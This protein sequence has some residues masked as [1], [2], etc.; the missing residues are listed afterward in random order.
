MNRTSFLSAY[1]WPARTM[2][3]ALIVSLALIAVTA[4]SA[5]PFRP[6]P[7]EVPDAVVMPRPTE[8][9]LEQ[10]QASLDSLM[11]GLSRAERAVFEEYPYLLQVTPRPALNSAIIPALNPR[12]EAKHE[13]N[14]ARAAL[15]NV[16]VLFMGDSITDFWRNETGRF[17]GKPVMDEYWSDLEIANFGIAGDTTEGVLYRLENGE[18]EGFSPKAIML[19]IGTNNTRANIAGEIAEGIGAVVLSLQKHFPDAKILL[20]AVFPRS[21]PDSPFRPQIAEINDIISRLHDGEKV[22]YKDIGQLFL[23]PDGS[24]PE[25]IM[26]DG[27]HPGEAGYR[28]WADAVDA[29]LRALM[30]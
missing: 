25:S 23:A 11:A 4:A 15:G 6:Q 21:T 1:P 14:K 5:Q 20:L 8:A 24:I 16:D 27:L 17:A 9:Q 3:Q 29:D 13:A 7:A 28:L 18:G 26:S 10:A 12:F 30:D 19:M 22:F 2:W